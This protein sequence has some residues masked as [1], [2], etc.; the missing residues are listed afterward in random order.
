MKLTI[1]L[2]TAPERTISTTSMV[3]ASVTLRP[4]MKVD[5]T[6]ERLSMRLI[7]GPPPCTTTGWAP[8]SLSSTTSAAN[9]RAISSSPM[10]WPPYLITTI[11]RS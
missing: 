11:S 10:A 3:A 5:S 1:S 6:P 4:S 2:L 8:T 9:R 7:W